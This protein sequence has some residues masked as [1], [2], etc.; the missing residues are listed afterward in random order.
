MRLP[1]DDWFVRAVSKGGSPVSKQNDVAAA[2]LAISTS[3]R[4]TD[5]ALALAEGAAS[6][7]GKV[8][9]ATEGARLQAHL[10]VHVVPAE[11]ESADDAVR[12]AET[13]V[14][15]EGGF[16]MTNLAPGRY[17]LLVRTIPEDQL[18]ERRPQPLAWEATS[19][20]KLRRDALAANVM[21]ELQRCQRVTD[22]LLKHKV[23]APRPAAPKKQ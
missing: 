1:T 15:N 19:R 7:R 4:V 10:Q 16:S 3:Q 5:L 22:Y 20:A 17:Y 12:F 11:Q 2:G 8:V 9:A 6:L 13:R 14:D 18:M 21:V 23:P